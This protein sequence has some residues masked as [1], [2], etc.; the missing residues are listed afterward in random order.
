MPYF[1]LTQLFWS[2]EGPLEH[3][4]IEVSIEQN[5][6]A[7]VRPRQVGISEIGIVQV[8]LQIRIAEVGCDKVGPAQTSMPGGDLGKASGVFLYLLVSARL[9]VICMGQLIVPMPPT[10]D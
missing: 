8:H 3:G 4:P 5:R 1:S 10:A 6:P 9:L 2:D 7:Q